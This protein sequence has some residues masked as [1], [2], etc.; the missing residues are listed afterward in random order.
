M[1]LGRPMQ[2]TRDVEQGSV[3]SHWQVSVAIVNGL[4]QTCLLLERTPTHRTHYVSGSGAPSVCHRCHPSTPRN[5]YAASPYIASPSPP[6][7]QHAMERYLQDTRNQRLRDVQALNNQRPTPHTTWGNDGSIAA[8]IVAGALP[9]SLPLSYPYATTIDDR[10]LDSTTYAGPA[11]QNS[12]YAPQ[13]DLPNDAQRRMPYESRQG[14][15]Q[16]SIGYVHGISAPNGA[17]PP[18]SRETQAESGQRE[19]AN[20]QEASATP[21][22]MPSIRHQRETSCR[23]RYGR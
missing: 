16:R 3:C 19:S 18:P 17:T 5:P 11:Q 14:Q 6:A 21:M 8:S 7:E 15:E 12:S 10:D 4:Y 23:R 9:S 20:G 1:F 2:G 22:P 13:Q